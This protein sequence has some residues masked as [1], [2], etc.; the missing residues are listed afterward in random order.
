MNATDQILAHQ[1][2]AQEVSLDVLREKY[3]KGDERGIAEVRARVARGLAACEA[4]A[5]RAE[6]EQ[7]FLWA[8]EQGFIP[9]GRINSAAGLALK[10]TLMNCFVQPVGDSITGNDGELPGIY[11][12]VAEAAETMRRGGGV[13]Y[14]FSAI[15]PLGAR[16]KGTQSRASGPVSYMEVF[17]ASCKTVESAGARR[18]AQMGV[19]RIDHPDIERFIHA[20]DQGDFRNFNLSVA[21]TDAFMQAVQDDAGFQLVHKA[22][23]SAE[24]VA[25]GAFQREDGLWVYRSLRARMLWDDI[26]HSTY[27]HAEPGILFIDRINEENNLWYAEQ[28]RATNPCGEQPV[29]AYGCCDLGSLNL[30]RFVQHPFSSAASFNFELMAQVA[31]L[32]VRM[33]DLAIDATQWPLQ[34]QEQEGRNKRRVGLGFL[35]QG[36]A[37]IMLGLR[38]DSE[39]ARRMAAR[40]AECLR[41]AAY[42]ASIE[43]AREK[44]PFPMLDRERHLQGRFIQRLPQHLQDGIRQHGIR[45]SHLLSVAPT[46]TISLAFADNAS[47]GIEPAYSWVY[48]RKKR[49]PDGSLRSYEVADHAWRL[50]R[51]L[52]HDMQS[53]LPPAFVTALEMSA[54]DHM[55]MMEAVQPYIDTSISKTVNIPEDY[56]YEEFKDLYL[57]AWQAGL[58]GLATYRPNAVLGSVL[59]VPAVPVPAP[60]QVQASGPAGDGRLAEDDPLRKQFDSRPL[61]PLESVTSKVEYFTQEGQKTVYLT[62]S[63]I[64]VDGVVDGNPVR[65]ERPFEFFMPAGQKSE[66]QQWT[67]ASMRLLS[68]VARSGGSIAGALGDMREVV[69]DK[70]PVRCG[71][72][73]RADGARVPLHHDS[74]V[75]A[76]GF[77]LQRLL[78]QRGFLDEDGGQVPVAVLAQAHGRRARVTGLDMLSTHLPASPALSGL[79]GKKCPECGAYALRKVDGCSH[80]AECHYVGE[81]G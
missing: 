12:A 56:P 53:A 80:C 31:A 35:G 43:L 69:W 29:P 64:E 26:M 32:G 28:L 30:T 7:R 44:G 61:G 8:Q 46:G 34:K 73:I 16:V 9:A 71:H 14:D 22:E 81:C 24:Q 10:A 33:L 20:K 6:M 3:A 60:A 58:K 13:G 42:A 70:G 37:L 1:L 59:S 65:I 45:N 38:Y 78:V 66:G 36:S 47:N 49:M 21:V 4:P 23:P 72:I 27:D 50:Y 17:D 54:T 41:D 79:S 39:Q 19:L 67:T 51:H 76:I 62:V 55:R 57:D 15:R 5:L 75:A 18:G 74:E 40:I 2:S 68:M 48:Q 52:G 63:F 77:M 25:E 11:T